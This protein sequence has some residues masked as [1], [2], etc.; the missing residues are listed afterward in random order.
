MR[1]FVEVCAPSILFELPKITRN[2]IDGFL[3]NLELFASNIIG[4]NEIIPKDHEIL[5][6]ALKTI[7][8]NN[9]A[10]LPVYMLMKPD[11]SLVD[12]IWSSGLP[13]QGFIFR[14]G[15]DQAPLIKLK[16]LE[17]KETYISKKHDDLA[18]VLIKQKERVMIHL[19]QGA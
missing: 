10:E 14:E 12:L 4:R 11:L 2:E 16:K 19:M 17:E 13:V 8:E 15:R 5:D 7:K 18:F 3:I 1:I 9:H 6:N